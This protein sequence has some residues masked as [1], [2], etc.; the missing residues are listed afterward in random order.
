VHELLSQPARHSS[1]EMENVRSD[2]TRVWVLWSYRNVM[3]EAWQQQILAIGV[4]VTDRRRARMALQ[5]VN[6]ELEERVEERT[7]ALAAAVQTLEREVLVREAAQR[8]LEDSQRILQ[9]LM[10]HIPEG[11]A[12]GEGA[13]PHVSRVSRYGRE[14]P[15][16]CIEDEGGVRK[17]YEV[18]HLDS[19][20]VACPDELPLSRASRT[21]E[22]VSDEE[23]VVRRPDGSLVTV[24]CNAGPILSAC[25]RRT[26][27]VVSWRDVT[28]RRRAEDEIRNLN[29][30][31]RERAAQ[32]EAT[33]KE[34]EA[35]AYSVTHD[36]RAPLRSI[37]G[38]AS[39]I[40]RESGHALSPRSLSHMARIRSNT[41]RMGEIIDDVLELSRSSRVALNRR[42]VDLAEM[43]LDIAAELEGQRP[44]RTVEL[45]VPPSLPAFGDPHLLRLVLRNLLDNAWK[46]TGGT[47]RAIVEVG[48]AASDTERIYFVRD[49]GVGFD[50]TYAHKLFV[51]FQRLH[52]DP[53]FSGT[54]VGLALV[55]R[56]IHRHGGRIWAES[57]DGSGAIFYFTLGEEAHPEASNEQRAEVH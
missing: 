45:R 18:L 30:S 48:V 43:A 50:P 25:G 26:G 29:T 4:D 34:L 49:N 27:G 40:L 32:L 52:T 20:T 6:A 23:W 12:V 13:L 41:A 16:V 47:E 36:L 35:F 15:M 1:L 11:I 3:D 44:G 42:L 38:F 31:L 7:R 54:G 21:G 57:G 2:G 14:L 28:E 19:A 33:N 37:D 22:V 39:V 46:F 10:E 51:P 9:A 53:R 8:S 17:R 55:Q 24:S 5:R 56:I